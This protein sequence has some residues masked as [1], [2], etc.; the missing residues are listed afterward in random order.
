[1]ESIQQGAGIARSLRWYSGSE[2]SRLAGGVHEVLRS[3]QM[4]WG[5][6][7]GGAVSCLNAWD[8]P[9]DEGGWQLAMLDGEAA[10]EP[11]AWWRWAHS[12]GDVGSLPTAARSL[13][14]E[15][16][17]LTCVSANGSC[18][19]I[20][21]EVSQ[22]AWADFW[23][24]L[25]LIFNLAPA[26]SINAPSDLLGVSDPDRTL[27]RP[28][29]GA[30]AL[31]QSCWGREMHILMRSAEASNLLPHRAPATSRSAT[32]LV[33]VWHAMASAPLQVR[34]ELA[35]VELTLGS[36]KGLRIGDVIELP[37]PLDRSL[38][39]KTISGEPICDAFLGKVGNNRAIE[40]LKPAKTA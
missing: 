39:V 22:A 20:E 23:Q 12:D 6:R 34:A 25:A 17:E 32:P 13:F 14:G 9:L 18:G 11:A 3:W 26:K 33:P 36:I 7:P 38:A 27:S 37:H 5:A 28:W 40:L 15:A 10:L 24:R 29:S 21:Q 16:P 8:I 30:V 35:P 1:M 31:V 2:L 4:D 19:E